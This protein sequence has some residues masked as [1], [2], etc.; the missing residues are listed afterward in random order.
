MIR[1]AVEEDIAELIS[2]RVAFLNEVNATCKPPEGFE[3][4]LGRYWKAALTDGTFESWVI[5]EAGRI[6][7]TGGICLHSI[8]PNYS[9]PSGKSA[10]V[11]NVFT[12]PECRGKGYASALFGRLID[13]ARALGCGQLYLHAT[14]AG[15]R[16][17]QKFG[18]L[19]TDDEMILHL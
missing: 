11:L 7:A 16:I 10:Y 15:R 2:L 5:E 9:N 1:M 4:N 12:L 8:A 13:R 18:F 19:Q 17:Y 3:Q 6:V 14:E